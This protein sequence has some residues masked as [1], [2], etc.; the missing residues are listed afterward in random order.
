[1]GVSQTTTRLD[2]KSR[3][4]DASMISRPIRPSF[5]SC[6][7]FNSRKDCFHSR[8]RCSDLLSSDLSRSKL[9]VIVRSEFVSFSSCPLYVGTEFGS[10]KEKR[11]QAQKRLWMAGEG[12]RD[13]ILVHRGRDAISV[14]LLKFVL[15]TSIS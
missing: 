5:H 7:S 14:A 9:L 15:V 11:S 8:L 1:M 4:P 3:T 6:N 12:E 13:G 2:C 10:R